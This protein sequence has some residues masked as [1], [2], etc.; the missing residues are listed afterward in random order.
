[1]NPSE[2]L[3]MISLHGC[4]SSQLDMCEKRTWAKVEE[5]V[6]SIDG[7]EK[8]YYRP[9]KVQATSPSDMMVVMYDVEDFMTKLN[10]PRPLTR[11]ACFDKQQQSR[12]RQKFIATAAE[13]VARNFLLCTD[14]LLLSKTC[15]PFTVP[16]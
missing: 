5:H 13:M 6:L 10:L 7:T 14:Q 12:A 1:M 4:R 2:N 8:F 16:W 3:D 15:I 11:Y 9:A